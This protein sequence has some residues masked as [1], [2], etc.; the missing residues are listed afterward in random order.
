MYYVIDCK[1][2]FVVH[3]DK[4]LEGCEQYIRNSGEL[5]NVTGLTVRKGAAEREKLIRTLRS[6]K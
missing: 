4:T 1:R 5:F 3:Q 2:K 6:E